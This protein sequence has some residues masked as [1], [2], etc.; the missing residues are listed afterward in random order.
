[1]S[2]LSTLLPA[3]ERDSS[4]V[5]LVISISDRLDCV[6]EFNILSVHVRP[7]T[8]AIDNLLQSGTSSLANNPIVQL[9]SSG[10]QATIGQVIIGVS[11]QVNNLNSDNIEQ[12]T[13]ST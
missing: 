13:S 2:S 8:T 9:L 5:H 12:A 11:Q 10:N 1:M 3:G 4:I 6:T 7:D